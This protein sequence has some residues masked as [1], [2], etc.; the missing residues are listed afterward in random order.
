MDPADPEALLG[1]MD[2]GTRPGGMEGLPMGM[3]AVID[4][5]AGATLS[6]VDGHPEHEHGACLNG[7]GM[8]PTGPTELIVID[9]EATCDPSDDNLTRLEQCAIH[10]IIEFP[11]VRISRETL[12]EVDYFHEFVR[13]TEHTELSE[14]CTELTGITQA[15]VDASAP[16]QE[17][18]GRLMQWFDERGLIDAL[19]DGR[20]VLVAHGL[21]DLLDMLPAECNRKG[22][23]LPECMT[24]FADL[25]AIFSE[26][27][28]VGSGLGML[29]MLERLGLEREGR[30]HSGLDDSRNLARVA[31]RLLKQ[32]ADFTP[33][34]RHGRQVRCQGITMRHGDWE[35]TNCHAAVFGSKENCF[36]CG[37]PR[38]AGAPAPPPS[39]ARRP[40]DWDCPACSA[41]VFASKVQCFRCNAPRPG[42]LPR[43]PAAENGRNNETRP[44]DW[45]CPNC[46]AN[47]YASK[48]ACFRCGTPRQMMPMCGGY[49]MQMCGGYGPYGMQ[50]YSPYGPGAVG[51]YG[52]GGGYGCGGCCY[53]GG[54]GGAY[55]GPVNGQYGSPQGACYAPVPPG[56]GQNG[57]FAPP[58]PG[59]A[60]PPPPNGAPPPPPNGMGPGLTPR[61]AGLS[62]A[63][64]A[65]GDGADEEGW[66]AAAEETMYIA[67]RLVGRLIGKGGAAIQELRDNSGASPPPTHHSHTPRPPLPR[68]PLPPSPQNGQAQSSRC[69]VLTS[70][71]HPVESRC[72]G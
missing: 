42:N 29:R 32:G 37:A 10:E 47:V 40:G 12:A 68:T 70:P 46:T 1:L 18:L 54:N 38:P 45:T 20:A 36:R 33:T 6:G 49:G 15:Q 13:P 59:Y 23:P 43:P 48:M 28:G 34:H 31:A 27:E 7:H 69:T 3:E 5:M 8:A 62:G 41:V 58:P 2:R 11:A 65:S 72:A 60:Y 57:G 22:V 44:G 71:A 67:S 9:L 14:F 55:P 63:P 56:Y 39:T 51:G 35:C 25:Q 26:A 50:G 24:V 17:V 16:L 21:W 66:S 53:V 52:G 61:M 30:H 19:R 64:A 4:G